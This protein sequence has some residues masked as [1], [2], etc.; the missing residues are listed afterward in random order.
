MTSPRR[1]PSGPRAG[2]QAKAKPR[3]RGETPWLV[4][5]NEVPQQLV[6][7]L[8]TFF[9]WEETPPNKIEEIDKQL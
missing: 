2:A 4:G 6:P 9:G 5:V 1:S 8:A 7:F 3:K